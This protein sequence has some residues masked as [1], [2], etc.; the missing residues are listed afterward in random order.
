MNDVKKKIGKRFGS[1]WNIFSE[2][3]KE[4]KELF[5]GWIYPLNQD[6][7]KGKT[8]LDAGCGGGQLTY[9]ALKFGA[10]KVVGVD[11]SDEAIKVA[12][13]RL[14]EFHNV[15]II[16]GD[17]ENLK[18]HNKF[19]FVYSIGVIHHTVNPEKAFGNLVKALK[20]KGALCVWVY[21][22]AGI[23]LRILQSIRIFTTRMPVPMLKSFS[24][25]TAIVVYPFSKLIDKF[26]LPVPQ[27]EFFRYMAKLSYRYSYFI[28]YDQYN[29]PISNYYKKEEFEEWF[30][31]ANLKN[32]T[33]TPRNNNSWIGIAV[34]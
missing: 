22:D 10:R 3:M 12:K 31:N 17:L 5:L 1:E 29:A 23:L 6:F 33:I 11:L 28:I 15:E 24:H 14:K 26:N 30:I 20:P 4:D 27:K 7:F 21:G 8:V 34:K 25:L 19:D 9:W 16:K 18:L 2:N 13:E 32:V